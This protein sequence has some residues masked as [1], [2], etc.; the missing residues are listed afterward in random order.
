MIMKTLLLYLIRK[1]QNIAIGIIV[2]FVSYLAYDYQ[3]L[4]RTNEQYASKTAVEARERALLENQY[5]RLSER[6]ERQE[7]AFSNHLEALEVI[8]KDN[9]SLR[10][11]LEE[12]EDERIRQ[13]L[14]TELSLDII[15]RLFNNAN[16]NNR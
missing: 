15:D 3:S 2:L 12:I 14:D 4:K 6:V 1:P 8:R 9:E 16:R 10:Q 13:S 7:Q 5:Q 11:D